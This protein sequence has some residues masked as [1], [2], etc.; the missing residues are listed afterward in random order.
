VTVEPVAE[1]PLEP[2]GKRLI[3]NAL[4]APTAALAAR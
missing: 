4:A 3:I 2:S 1:I